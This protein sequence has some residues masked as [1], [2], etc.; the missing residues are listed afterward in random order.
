VGDESD[1]A[2][3]PVGVRERETRLSEREKEHAGALPS[4]PRAK[5][6]RERKGENT[7]L[8]A[9][10]PCGGVMGRRRRVAP[11]AS[12]PNRGRGEIKL[13]FLFS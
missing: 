12:R 8:G 1:R 2:I 4:G 5:L 3:P 6:G 9:A 10:G 11:W 7:G 13:F